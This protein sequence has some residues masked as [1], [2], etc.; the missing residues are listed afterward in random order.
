MHACGE[1]YSRLKEQWKYPKEG[2][3]RARLEH[4]GGQRG[5]SAESKVG[6][7][8]CCRLFGFPLSVGESLGDGLSRGDSHSCDYCAEN[9]A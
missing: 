7:R 5:Q 6:P 8:G 3:C 4:E 9:R 1:E 2:E